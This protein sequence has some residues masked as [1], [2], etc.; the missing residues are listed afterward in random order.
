MANN[1]NHQQ[2]SGNII[3]QKLKIGALNVNSI[4]A[5]YRRYCLQKFI[6]TNKFDVLLISE[7]K[8][9]SIH[10]P[11]FKGC[12]FV[13][14]NRPTAGGGGTGILIADP[15]QYT[16]INRPNSRNNKTLEYTVIKIFPTARTPILIFSIYAPPRNTSTFI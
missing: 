8:L 5:M 15:I 6:D 13:R 12:K 9:K 11:Q 10:Q 14:T 2:I 3:N 16:I 4:V 1:N 7:T